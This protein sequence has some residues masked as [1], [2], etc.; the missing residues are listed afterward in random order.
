MS[1]WRR[2]E[3]LRWFIGAESSLL[4]GPGYSL[5]LPLWNDLT[6][7]DGVIDA[8][9]APRRRGRA[10][11][12]VV[13][14]RWIAYTIT[15]AP[16]MLLRREEE[17]AMALARLTAT[18]GGKPDEWC[19]AVQGQRPDAGI[20]VAG[21][22]QE[23]M[24]R[25]DAVMLAA[26]VSRHCVRPLTDAA[27]HRVP[28]IR[29]GWWALVEPRWICLLQI[30]GGA[31]REVI[32][33]AYA[34]DSCVALEALLAR[35]DSN[36]TVHRGIHDVWVQPLGDPIREAELAQPWT[37]RWILPAGQSSWDWGQL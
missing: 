15:S 29:D 34:G 5:Q 13:S 25:I 4:S 19:V 16:A 32:A 22:R 6:A 11:D 23:M 20:L 10:L 33:Q 31:W 9:R 21:M 27:A 24:R 1:L 28:R 3:P 17:R 36:L 37:T 14:N 2:D 18:F 12:I 8:L 30:V 26:E 35:H 7:D